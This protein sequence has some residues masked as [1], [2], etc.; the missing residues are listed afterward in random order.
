MNYTRIVVAAVAAT[1]VDAVYGFVVYGNLLT[2][3]FSAYPGVYRAPATQG[4]YMPILFAGIFIAMLAASFIYAKGYEGGSGAAEGL[5]FGIVLGLVAVGYS[6]LV[7]YSILNIGRRLGV[8]MTCASLVEWI[9]A[10]LVIGLTYK[11]AVAGA[12]QR[13]AV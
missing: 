5:R 10:G 11:P 6:A 9:V 13:A 7:S 8:S 12:R 1:I 4:A 2:A 3:Q